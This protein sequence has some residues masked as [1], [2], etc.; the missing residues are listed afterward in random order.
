MA[1]DDLFQ[2]LIRDKIENVPFAHAVLNGSEIDLKRR[3]LLLIVN[4][5][6]DAV[7]PFLIAHHD[8]DWNTWD[9]IVKNTASQLQVFHND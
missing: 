7:L 8:A 9:S 2:Y 5:P 4:V 3:V 1:S 6:G